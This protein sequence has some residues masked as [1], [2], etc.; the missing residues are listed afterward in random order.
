MERIPA[1]PPNISRMMTVEN[2]GRL[3]LP[4]H[5]PFESS[6]GVDVTIQVGV[7]AELVLD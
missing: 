3:P 1:R 7:L 6:E 2:L 5:F 4:P